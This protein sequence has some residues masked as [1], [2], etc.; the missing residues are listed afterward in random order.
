MNGQR[1]KHNLYPVYLDVT[2]DQ[3][4][5]YREHLSRSAAKLKRRNNLIVKL[6]YGPSN[7]GSL[8]NITPRKACNTS[9]VAG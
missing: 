8:I 1:L 3:T 6:A 5:S 2:L 9:K 4:L 7:R